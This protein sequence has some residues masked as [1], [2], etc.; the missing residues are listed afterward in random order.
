MT[1]E[2]LIKRINDLEWYDFEVKE[3]KSELPKSIWETVSAFANTSGGWIVLGIR[4]VGRNFIISGVDNIEKLEQDFLGTI[5][6]Q[7]FNATVDA[8]ITKYDI[9]GKKVLAFHIASSPQK[10][11]YFN[12]PQNTFIRFG[13]GDQ[14][15]TNAEIAAMFRN[16]AFG[17]KSE[18]TIPGTDI[19]MLNHDSLHGYRNYMKIWGDRPELTVNDDGDFCKKLGICDMNGQLNYGGLIMFGKYEFL[20]EYVPTFWMDLVEI[21]GDN[22]A[23]AKVRYT[24]RI[25]EQDNLWEYYMVLI[26]RLRL[27]VNTPFKM[28][29]EGFNVEDQ[30]QFK[31]LREALVNMLIHADHFSTIHSCIHV[32]TN[33]VEFFNAGAFPIPIE[34]I[35]AK[36]YSNP[37]NPT[38]AKL[39]RLVHLSETVGYG[40][41]LMREWKPATGFEM[42]IESDI[43]STTVTFYLQTI[44]DNVNVNDN[45]N[46]NVNIILQFCIVPKSRREILSHIGLAYHTDA[47]RKHIEPLVSAGLIELT[48]PEKPKSR[49]QQFITTEK[50]KHF[51]SDKSASK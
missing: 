35:G 30:S 43:T 27:L 46:D 2:E 26:K 39:F 42:S 15:A 21:S 45:V 25:P 1:K 51:I 9:E 50:G 14:R 28:N 29:S 49:N 3:A 6:S 33:R 17:V 44:N 11:I 18:Q 37:R 12:N 41:D 24:Y 13:S 4:Q 22:V 47:Y 5:R 19:G 38:I 23:E 31:I 8:Q 48:I 34:Q 40:M 7:K 20:R 32:Y 36:L 16:Q 10:P